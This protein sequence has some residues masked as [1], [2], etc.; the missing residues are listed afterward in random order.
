MDLQLILSK[1]GRKV[2]AGGIPALGPNP[3]PEAWPPT[4]PG[5]EIEAEARWQGKLAGW[6]SGGPQ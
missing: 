2:E 4:Q 5:Q 1:A 6:W 3:Q